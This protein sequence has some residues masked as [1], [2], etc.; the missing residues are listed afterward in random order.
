MKVGG[1]LIGARGK[2]RGRGKAVLG[3]LVSCGRTRGKRD[4]RGGA[5]RQTLAVGSSTFQ[6]GSVMHKVRV[7]LVWVISSDEAATLGG[8]P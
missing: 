6:G 1:R 3:K 2:F 7:F 8:Y 5:C 4:D